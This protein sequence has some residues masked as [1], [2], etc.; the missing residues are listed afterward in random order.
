MFLLS[1]FESSKQSLAL[2]TR[3]T[4]VSST[5]HCKAR[6]FKLLLSRLLIACMSISSNDIN[7]LRGMPKSFKI[8][9][10]PFYYIHYINFT[11]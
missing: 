9:I 8:R 1:K 7:S 11:V 5:A 3:Y 2:N 6:S 4:D 10:Y